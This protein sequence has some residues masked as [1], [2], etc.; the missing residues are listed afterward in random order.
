V[1]GNHEDTAKYDALY[2]RIKRDF[3]ARF[4]NPTLGY[5]VDP[6]ATAFMSQGVQV[7][8]LAMDLVPAAERRGLQE[9]LVNDV[10][11]TR[12]GHQ[13]T[14]I[15]SAR[16]FYPVL[17][18]A[19][20]EGVPNAAKAA[21]T[22]AQQTTYPSY[23]YWFT[24]L[25]FT[26]VGENWEQGTRTRNHEMFGTIAQWF[27]EEVAGIKNLEPGFSKVQ[28]RPL[29]TP[30]GIESASASYDSNKGTIKSSW[31]Q[32]TLGIRMNVTIPANTTAKVYVPGLDP[33][34]VGEI[35]TGR[36]LPAK[37]APGVQLLGVEQDAVVFEVGSGDYEFV[38]GEGLFKATEATAPVGGTVPATLSLTLGPPATF[39]TFTP[40]VAR[41]Y[42]ATT[43]ANVIST[44]GD[45]AL[46]VAPQPAYLANGSFTLSEPLQVAFSKATW[47]APVANDPVT[48]T[49]RQPIAANQALRTGTYSKTLTFTLSTTNP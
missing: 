10:L 35:A 2:E 6:V 3:N 20:H 12:T 41:T 48:I 1:L 29:I 47:T 8:A 26:G 13:L 30:D 15:A 16:W 4:W 42:E 46:S 39:G 40:G 27:Y 21:Y 7:L 24:T 31:S 34:A 32:S 45:A 14:G 11:V 25:G 37:H 33:N 44:A 49:F 43:T 22:A 17:T 19:A 38:V 9:K 28:I 5:Y 23:G 18:E 36:A